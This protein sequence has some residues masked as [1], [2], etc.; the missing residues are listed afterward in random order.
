M[1]DAQE[2]ARANY[3][4]RIELLAAACALVDVVRDTSP[5]RYESQMLG[6][7][8]KMLRQV[9]ELTIWAEVIG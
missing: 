8:S 4:K 6:E 9:V 7:A 5:S 3:E 1:T 2:T